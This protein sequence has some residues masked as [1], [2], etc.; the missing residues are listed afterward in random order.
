MTYTGIY[1]LTEA[2]IASKEGANVSASVTD[3]MH[4]QWVNEAANYINTISRRVWAVD[5]AAFAAL[6]TDVRFLLTGYCSCIAALY[7]I[8]YDMSGYTS[9]IEAENMIKI[10]WVTSRK[11]A[12]LIVQQNSVTFMKNN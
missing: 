2:E 10:L 3:V 6:S 5:A 1:V 4:T 11:Y 12:D 8:A 9:R 7:G